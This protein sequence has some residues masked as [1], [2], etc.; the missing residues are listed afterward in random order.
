MRT[1]KGPLPKIDGETAKKLLP[2]RLRRKESKYK[3]SSYKPAWK[4]DPDRKLGEGP[5]R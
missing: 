2:V 1:E 4:L 3:R 5:P